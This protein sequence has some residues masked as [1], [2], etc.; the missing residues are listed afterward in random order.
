MNASLLCARECSIVSSPPLGELLLSRSLVVVADFEL[1]NEL[2]SAR[3]GRLICMWL[4]RVRC[5]EP[6]SRNFLIVKRPFSVFVRFFILVQLM[7]IFCPILTETSENSHLVANLT[8]RNLISTY[9]NSVLQTSWLVTL[10]LHGSNFYLCTLKQRLQNI[11]QIFL[12]SKRNPD[13]TRRVENFFFSST[14]SS[15]HV[16]YISFAGITCTWTNDKFLV[17]V[18]GTYGLI[19]R[20]YR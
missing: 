17:F 12:Q 9:F 18:A 7:F 8:S 5:T 11:F 10:I 13:C 4:A 16:N 1:E 6:Q 14:S 2:A 20:R 3:P 15:V 19:Y